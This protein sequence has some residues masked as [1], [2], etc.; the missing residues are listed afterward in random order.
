M[1]LLTNGCSWT[2]GGGLNLD[3]PEN[4]EERLTKVWPYHLGKL[5]QTNEVV[6][7]A[8]GC[9]SNQRT[10]RTTFEWLLK[11]TP[12][13][14]KETVAVIQWTCP[15]R[16]EYYE[17]IDYHN[18]LEN[19]PERWARIKVDVCLQSDHS[20]DGY[21][22]A[23]ERSQ[24][25]FEISSYQESMYETV[26]RISALSLMFKTFGVEHFYWNHSN[27]AYMYPE[28]IKNYY[29]NNFPWI[30]EPGTTPGV[31][32]QRDNIWNYDLIP[33]DGHPSFQGHR[34]LADIIYEKIK[35]KR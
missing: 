9:G 25:R 29:C 28:D 15:D 21:K 24:R 10:V 2:Y 14:L 17:P 33:T 12:E 7:L 20:P 30:D 31:F 16:Y 13:R 35:A 19:I 3:K 18:S 11:Q 34:E 32:E 22:F 8:E 26:N 27:R 6:Q 5:L 4:T 1:I 23:F